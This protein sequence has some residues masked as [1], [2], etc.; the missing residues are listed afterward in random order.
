MPENSYMKKL[1]PRDSIYLAWGSWD[2]TYRMFD[3][4]NSPVSSNIGQ[5]KCYCITEQH[6]VE[7]GLS[8]Q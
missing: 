3:L 1:L 5:G 2:G 6:C 7:P 4:S 8:D